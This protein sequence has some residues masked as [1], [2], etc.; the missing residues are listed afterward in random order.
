MALATLKT[1]TAHWTYAALVA[2]APG[3]LEP[4]AMWFIEKLLDAALVRQFGLNLHRV[5]AGDAD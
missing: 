1:K 2:G 3:N 5:G 4:P